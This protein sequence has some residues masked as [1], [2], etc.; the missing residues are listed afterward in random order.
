M[1]LTFKDYFLFFFT[2][3]ENYKNMPFDFYYTCH[4]TNEIDKILK[5]I[6]S[7]EEDEKSISYSIKIN[8]IENIMKKLFLKKRT[9]LKI[10]D[11]VLKRETYVS[12]C[13][14]LWYYSDEHT[15][16]K[17]LKSTYLTFDITHFTVEQQILLHKIIF[18]IFPLMKHQVY[19]T[20]EIDTK[21]F[22]ESELYDEYTKDIDT[23]YIYYN[24]I[25]PRSIDIYK[26]VISGT[27]HN[28]IYYRSIVPNTKL[29]QFI[30]NL[31]IKKNQK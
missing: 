24:T 12:F 9:V 6:D 7:N 27:I 14:F 18:N 28:T 21:D 20:Y 26:E 8:K 19:I 4:L 30:K 13:G 2:T 22:S 15:R 3:N 11:L 23:P 17:M 16:F 1:S 29:E 5:T 25:L 31:E 10:L